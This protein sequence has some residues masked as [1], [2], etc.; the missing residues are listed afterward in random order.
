M[1]KP[2]AAAVCVLAGLAAPAPRA[3]AQG[4]P[5]YLLPDM[6]VDVNSLYENAI[7]VENGRTLLRLSNGTPNI[8]A[9]KLYMRGGAVNG[10][11]TQDVWQRIYRED[12]V[13]WDRLAGR[14]VHHAGHN[15]IHVEGWALYRLRERFDEVGVGPVV[16]TSPKT[17]FCL[18]DSKPYDPTAP[19]Y[20]PGGE[21]H[22]CNSDTQGISVGWMDVYSR[23]LEGQ[24]IDITGIP[25]GD[26]WLESE[27]DPDDGIL[28]ENAE[29]NIARIPIIISNG[30]TILPDRFEPNDSVATVKQRP[31]GGLNSPNLGPVGPSA[32]LPGL[33]LHKAAS[34]DY[35]RF[36]SPWTGTSDSWGMIEF[37]PA[38]GDLGVRLLSDT[39]TVLAH[40][41]G[42]GG[43]RTVGM[44]GRPAGW[45]FLH[46]YG[47]MG[48]TQTD[49]TLTI[50]PAV[51]PAPP[52]ITVTSP[53]AGDL[54]L[55]HGVDTVKVEWKA[56]DSNQNLTWVT[57]YLST[58]G[59]LD[60]S[61]VLIPTSLHTPGSLGYHYV[62]S[63]YLEPGT[64]WVYGAI[65]DGA[66]WTG[67]WSAGT[68]TFH[69][70]DDHC[71]GDINHD[72]FVNGDDFDQ[73]AVLFDAGDHGADIDHNE[74][75][76]G[77]DFDHFMEAFMAGC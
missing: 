18:L 65:T 4:Q 21:F 28:E 69:E 76:N 7:T 9:G 32:V 58:T 67:G 73:F 53:P 49:Y 10:D 17:S 59:A 38:R 19:G 23:D 5:A 26:Y 63:A 77:D 30:A 33:T 24:A 2:L 1:K 22:S 6:T 45:Y 34:P 64:Y 75:V 20:I 40:G 66:S 43:V 46:V 35:F 39:G 3:V 72:G 52:V 70:H 57:L 55:E 44:L 41:S 51:S 48:D 61:E 37:D 56:S 50:K 27:V 8:G 25:D 62:N 74:F 42:T 36:Y 47:I 60:G 29:N 68:V 12:G 71:E 15:H 54:H 16:A 11:G 31:I 13:H 14:F